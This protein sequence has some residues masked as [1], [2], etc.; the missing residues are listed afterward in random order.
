MDLWCGMYRLAPG[1]DLKAYCAW[2]E[3]AAVEVRELIPS[4][5]RNWQM[6]VIEETTGSGESPSWTIIETI[7]ISDWREWMPAWESSDRLREI[8]QDFGAWID[9]DS[10]RVVYGRK[11]YGEDF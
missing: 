6:Y 10:L 5:G 9:A 11:V 8:W 3:K 1:A 2:N 7:E 4:I